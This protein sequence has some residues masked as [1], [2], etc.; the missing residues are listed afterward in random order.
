MAT[1]M[2][3]S[4]IIGIA[5][6]IIV[7]TLV[8]SLMPQ[9]FQMAGSITSI[10][11]TADDRVRTGATIVNYDVPAPGRLQFDVLNNGK[12]SMAPSRIN[13]T[14]A[15]LYNQ[16]MPA[17]LL[18]QGISSSA[19][20]WEYAV[21]GNGD[22]QWEPGEVL[23]VSVISPGYDFAPGEYTLKMLLYNGAVVQYRF[24]I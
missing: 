24:T 21:T 11:G 7:S 16:S 4:A 2:I 18:V 1:D 5:A 22:S 3:S 14:V 13:M 17:H 9:I 19:Q 10:S 23:E 12:A 20:Y 6:L 15:Y 8:A